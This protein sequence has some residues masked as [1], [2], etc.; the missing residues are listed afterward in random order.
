MNDLLTCKTTMKNNTPH[1]IETLYLMITITHPP[2]C[3]IKLTNTKTVAKNFPQPHDISIYSLCSFHWN[4]IRNP[5]SRKV[6]MR[7]NLATV[8]RMCFPLRIT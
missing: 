1:A 4:H 5:S 2:N 8:G 6:E 3:P 7:H